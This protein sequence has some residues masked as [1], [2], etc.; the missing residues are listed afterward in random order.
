MIRLFSEKG[1][2]LVELIIAVVGLSILAMVVIPRIAS[3]SDQA[4][5]AACKQ[6]QKL[7][8]CACSFYYANNYSASSSS[9]LASF[10]NRLSDLTPDYLEEIPSCP[11]GGHYIY[12]AYT[13]IVTCS[14]ISHSRY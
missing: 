13:G 5:I 1:F 6:N 12:G 8:T 14:E 11:G 3:A 10:P 2:T 9:K 4:K 7:I